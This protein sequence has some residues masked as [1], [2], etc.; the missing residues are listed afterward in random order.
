MSDIKS[1]TQFTMVRYKSTRAISRNKTKSH[2]SS[3]PQ[4]MFVL[5]CVSLDL[6]NSG[7]VILICVF[8]Y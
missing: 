1:K 5:A 3:W 7:E 8:F 2:L 4:F 6:V